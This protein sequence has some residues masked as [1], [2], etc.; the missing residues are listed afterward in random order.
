MRPVAGYVGGVLPSRPG[1]VKAW[2]VL[3]ARVTRGLTLS[4]LPYYIVRMTTFLT[5]RQGRHIAYHR[6]E[7][8]GPGVVFL[9]GFRSDMSGSKALFLQSWAKATGRAFLRFDYSGHGA[10][11]GAFVDG[12]IGDWRD[13]AA[14]VIKAA[15]DGPQILVGSSMGGWISLLLARDMPS[16]VAGLVGIAAA[17][18]FTER[19]WETEFPPAD[20]ARLLQDGVLH[21]PS[22]YS[23]EPY[24]ITRRLIEDGRQNLVL[25]KPLVLPFPVRLL[26]GT[27][28]TDVPPSVALGLLD[29][30]DC[31]D[32]RL[33]LVKDADHRF[34]TPD[35]LGLITG[36][37]E[38]VLRIAGEA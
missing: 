16:R 10:S 25:D 5:T 28:D 26:Q 17:P 4:M 34:S 24:P 13:D 8:R 14:E 11:H 3:G 30:I 9:G 29:H 19:M 1:E 20:R 23:D 6:T 38:D 33:T 21:R 15:T 22:D 18:D 35:C 27:A 32:L 37:V 31:P 7:G 2:A 36:T 12:A